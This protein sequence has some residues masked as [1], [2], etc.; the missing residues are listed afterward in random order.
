MAY[1]NPDIS[2]QERLRAQEASKSGN[3][4]LALV[5]FMEA[6]KRNPEDA[7][8]YFDRASVFMTLKDHESALNDCNLGTEKDPTSATGYLCKGGV[9]EAMKKYDAAMDNYQKALDID[10]KL[11]DASKAYYRCLTVDYE[12]RNNPKQ[13]FFRAQKSPAISEILSDSEI[14]SMLNHLN[15]HP[16]SIQKYLEDPEISPKIQKL[17]DYG[18]IGISP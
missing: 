17:I 11:K 2:R 16:D 18:I 8:L 13:T 4:D 14:K 7:Q 6:I 12:Q 5:H 15:D 10:P 9:L 3:Q 1:I